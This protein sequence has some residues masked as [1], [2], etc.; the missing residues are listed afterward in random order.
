MILKKAVEQVINSGVK[1]I[2]LDVQRVLDFSGNV[3][4][5]RTSLVIRSLELG[6]LTANEYRFVARRTE[7]GSKLVEKNL[8]KLFYFYH[9]LKRICTG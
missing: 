9:D 2:V 6:V 8:D 7:Q 5:L 1:P 4:G 3:E